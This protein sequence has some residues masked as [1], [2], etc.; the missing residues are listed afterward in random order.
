MTA[1]GSLLSLART[2]QAIALV[3]EGAKVVKKKKV[4]TKDIVGLGIKNI[5]GVEFIKLQAQAAS[6]L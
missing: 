3:G 6:G 5:V 2:A 4:K 1:T